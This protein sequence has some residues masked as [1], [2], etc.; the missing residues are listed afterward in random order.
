MVITVSRIVVLV[1]GISMC[2]FAAWGIYAPQKLLQFVKRMMDEDWGI[3]FAVIV[4]LLLGVALII[5]APDSRFPLTFLILGWIAIVAAVVAAFM[6]R[7]RL[8][9]FI[10]WWIERFSPAGVRVWVLLAMAFGGFLIY[11][12][13]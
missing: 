3:Y 10:N 8:R 2:M 13:L 4:R 5:S 1:L 11:G 6:G 9:S 12:V 7:G